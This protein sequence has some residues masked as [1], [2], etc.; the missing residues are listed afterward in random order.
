M[1]KISVS[2]IIPVYN[3]EKN[4]DRCLD[5][6]KA[7][8]L[9]SIEVIMIDDGSTDDSAKICR[10]YA[11]NDSR[12]ILKK[13]RKKGASSARNYGISIARG[14]YIGF[15]DSDDSISNNMFEIMYSKA[16]ENEADICMCDYK[17]IYSEE[18]YCLTEIL[19][20][21][22]FEKDSIQNNMLKTLF[23]YFSESG[24]IKDVFGVV[25]R[26]IIKRDLLE[27]CQIRFDENLS[28]FEDAIF[29][30]IATACSNKVYYLK[31]AYLYNYFQNTNGISKKYHVD[32]EKQQYKYIRTLFDTFTKKNIK[33]D[34]ITKNLFLLKC[35]RER[36]LNISRG[37]SINSVKE[38]YNK[39]KGIVNDNLFREAVEN[40]PDYKYDDEYSTIIKYTKEKK[41]FSLYRYY[42][43][44][45]YNNHSF[46]RCVKRS[47]R[48]NLNKL[49]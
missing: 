20:E 19:N 38:S 18:S 6:V 42:Y 7:Q 39:I 13:N 30:F 32:F 5:S 17:L 40:V 41:I 16:K 3:T 49:K 1:E 11:N 37:F 8:T 12:F 4:L 29:V 23:A 45:V 28:L 34:E 33:I 31:Q 10:K 47:I 2:I 25:W 44:K 26:R 9:A 36:Y 22:L 15:V 14:E 21:G 46:L 48:R 27:K 35:M 24:K 43:R